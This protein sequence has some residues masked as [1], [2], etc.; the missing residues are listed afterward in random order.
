MDYRE[1]SVEDFVLDPFFRSWVNDRAG[2]GYWEEWLAGNPDKLAIVEEAKELILGLKF[3]TDGPTDTEIH[4]VKE[5]I[6]ARLAM[7][8]KKKS[9]PFYAYPLAASAAFLLVASVAVFFF[10]FS[11]KVN[12]STAFSETR[13]L[14]LPDGSEVMLNANSHISYTRNWEDDLPRE[15]WLEGEAFFEVKK[16][17]ERK[18]PKFLVHVGDLRVEVLGTSFN[19]YNRDGRASVVLQEGKVQLSSPESASGS[20]TLVMAPGD[21]VDYQ[22]GTYEIKKVETEQYISWKDHRMVFENM[23]LSEIAVI[24]EDNYGYQPV[25]RDPEIKALRFT[26]SYSTEKVGILLKAI[27]KSFDIQVIKNGK[28]ITFQ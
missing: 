1:F 24:L 8:G 9:R 13:Q 6:T 23:E 4:E 22:D 28:T 7:I 18:N 14:I 25:F 11:P 16:T 10:I 15:V 5:R 3:R 12:E 26:G 19:V 21:K 27:E 2:N 17:P 20:R